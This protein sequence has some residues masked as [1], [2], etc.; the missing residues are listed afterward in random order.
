MKK[1]IS[2]IVAIFV[3][4][5]GLLFAAFKNPVNQSYE[6]NEAGYTY[7]PQGAVV[8]FS[9]KAK[10]N[11]TW[12]NNEKVIEDQS[13]KKAIDLSRTLF[14]ENQEIQFLGKSVAIIS[15]QQLDELPSFTHIQSEKNSYLAKTDAAKTI[16]SIPKG[17]V[18]KL[19]EGRYIIL[20]S[21]NLQ[22]TTG[23]NKKLKDNAIVVIDEHQK[24][25]ISGEGESEE[26]KSDDLFITMENSDYRFDLTTERLVS[27]N[28]EKDQINVKEIKV[29]MD[30]KAGRRQ[31]NQITK[32]TGQSEKS[33][34]QQESSQESA[35]RNTKSDSDVE[36]SAET[37]GGAAG[38]SNSAGET[39]G[40]TAN[41]STGQKA[42]EGTEDSLTDE[43]LN[44]INDVINKL[45]KLEENPAFTVPLVHVEATAVK[46]KI[47]GS[48]KINDESSRLEKLTVRLTQSGKVVQQQSI[49]TA[50]TSADFSFEELHYGNTYQLLVEGSYKYNQRDVQTVTFYRKNFTLSPVKI[51]KKIIAT[52]SDALTIQMEA[53]DQESQINELVLKYKINNSKVTEVREITVKAS[54]LN[55]EARTTILEL[56]GLASNQEYLIEMA[57]LVVDGQEVTDNS[58]YL[59]GKTKKQLP[60]LESLLLEYSSSDAQFVVTPQN[61][62]DPDATITSIRYVIYSEEDYAANGSQAEN[63]ASAT[64]NTA[65]K[66]SVVRIGRTAGMPNGS[67]VAVAYVTGNDDQSDYELTPVQSNTVVI[68]TKTAPTIRFDLKTAKQDSLDI[69][70]E[71]FDQDDTV[72][73]N[74]LT[75]PVFTIYASDANGNIVSEIPEQTITVDSEAD[76]TSQLFVDGLK[77]ETYYVA[78]LTASYNLDDGSGIQV[79]QEIGR[80]APYKTLKVQEVTADFTQVAAEE[81]EAAVNI[82][83][84]SAGSVLTSAV[85]EVKNKNTGVTLQTIEITKEMLEKMLTENGLELKISELQH[86]S[87]YHVAFIEAY[88][89]GKNSMS[90]NGSGILKTRKIAPQ[91]DRIL[92]KYDQK[93]TQ[94][95]ALVAEASTETIID[96]DASV[97]A[98]T[99]QIFEADSLLNDEKAEPLAEKVITSDF[100]AYAYFD[101]LTEELGRGKTYVIRA[102]VRWNDRYDEHEIVLQSDQLAIDKKR[103]EVE[104][105]LLKRDATGITMKVFIDDE[106]NILENNELTIR[107]GTDQVTAKD[108]QEIKIPVT[109]GVTIQ[110]EGRYRLLADGPLET[111]IFQEKH[112]LALNSEQPAVANELIFDE[113]ERQ[114]LAQATVSENNGSI[115]ASRQRIEHQSEEVFTSFTVG[116]NALTTQRFALPNQAAAIWFNNTYDFSLDTTV[117]YA[118]NQLDN[119][120]FAGQYNI[121]IDDGAK[122]VSST[123][124]KITTAGNRS[125]AS[126]YQLSDLVVD[127]KGNVDSVSFK[128]SVTEGYLGINTGNIVDNEP[129]AFQFS[130]ERQANGSY[131]MMAE[132]RYINFNSGIVSQKNQA[133]VIDLYS[134]NSAQASVAKQI[135]LPELSEPSATIDKLAVYDKQID[136]DFLVVD[137]DA[138]LLKTN[139]DQLQLYVNVYEKGA[140]TPVKSIQLNSLTDVQATI[141]GLT[142]ETDYTVK[143]EAVYDLL[144]GAGSQA[145]VLASQDFKTLAAAPEITETTYSWSPN[146]YVENGR[147]IVN[148][149]TFTDESNILET[150]EYR[151][152]ELTSDIQY[153][154]NVEKM[155][156]V[157]ANKTPVTVY[158]ST[159]PENVFDLYDE[160][161]K[162]RFVSGKTYIIA[163][164]IKTTKPNEVP[165][166]LSNINKITIT[167]PATPTSELQVEAVTSKEAD[168]KFSYNDPHGYILSGS[169]KPF[170]Y[171]LTETGT[172]TP[173]T[174]VEGYTGSFKGSNASTWLKN[175]KGLNPSTGYTLTII[176]SYDNLDGQKNRNWS[177]QV[178]FT[179]S[180]EY[181]TSNP[182][183][184]ILNGSSLTLKVANLNNGSATITGS[185]LAL[186]QYNAQTNTIGAQVAEKTIPVATSYPIDVSEQFDISSL[187]SGNE[188][189]MARLE[190]TYDTDLGERDQMYTIQNIVYIGA[191]RSLAQPLKVNAVAQGLTVQTDKLPTDV[192]NYTVI[193]ANERGQTVAKTTATPAQLAKTLTI[194]TDH[195]AVSR[196]TVLN[197]ESLA[198][199]YQTNQ[200]DQT[201]TAYYT[202][203]QTI[204]KKADALANQQYEVI[205]QKAEKSLANQLLKAV[206]T[207][208]VFK[209]TTFDHEQLVRTEK[210]TAKVYNVT[211][212]ELQEGYTLPCSIN[213]NELTIKEV[214]TGTELI[215]QK[216]EV[217]Q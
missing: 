126:L 47:K 2:L 177:R 51:A 61:L 94:L 27:L 110:A 111:A 28:D 62:K 120:N 125:N 149:T 87:D 162:Q 78:I 59:I 140:E 44:E 122:V 205:V 89:S 33:S 186:Y 60:E 30:D 170:T 192:P 105:Q 5:I 93:N 66:N 100:D 123:N 152:Y 213:Q 9:E 164:Y 16:G 103:P 147:K 31:K 58:W 146:V 109:A 168:L 132:N 211:G 181:V 121:V 49:G 86:N 178:V 134:V 21:A 98:I 97:T 75:K 197:E 101:L 88:D 106:D 52:G 46:Q 90:I 191:T 203:Q 15:N 209:T 143:I 214:Q 57:R 160:K 182:L 128:N 79:N 172:G 22:N 68:G 195:Q 41:Q 190:V 83:L 180:D 54:E 36:Q 206:K 167:A 108:G 179:T 50:E 124:G 7:S 138:V 77:S 194:P 200:F 82:K 156:A 81:T 189:L 176:G 216:L 185:R 130:L 70:Y 161:G 102:S 12:I 131:V 96:E 112:L 11:N 63:Y 198:A 158:T 92:L 42:G 201:A 99:F 85:L 159:A 48:L 8:Q 210:N 25:R 1:N 173:A 38:S 133:S 43:Q 24:I 71:L 137:K 208:L 91:A 104:F 139:S 175:F 73:I 10:Y 23:L 35:E 18:V 188:Y 145:E 155:K 114:L 174:Y 26:M 4:V 32:A 196:V 148:T 117:Y 129:A 72:I 29:E 184:Y 39:S 199:S 183:I 64:V 19:A 153:S 157:L 45:N 165:D 80:S 65:N 69:R 76:F 115:I 40:A 193:V 163:A 212:A 171:M 116:A 95:G 135:T 13:K 142:A 34:S 215:I 150:I 14:L 204:L 169:N 119:Q 144:E 84:D 20:D 127:E 154:T 74:A 166:F 67:Y 6:I 118:E 151:L 3:A 107:S 113:N 37:T 141:N 17:T 207:G 55:S 136:M 202:K 56:T 187:M 217:V 53:S